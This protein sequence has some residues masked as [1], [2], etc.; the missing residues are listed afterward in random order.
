MAPYTG[1]DPHPVVE[2]AAFL[3]NEENEIEEY[4]AV[5]VDRASGNV[6]AFRT[7]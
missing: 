5:V 7:E 1:M 6:L 2:I 4:R 3:L